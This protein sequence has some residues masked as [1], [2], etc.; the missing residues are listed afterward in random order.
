MGAYLIVSMTF[1]DLGWTKAYLDSV[2]E[3]VKRHGGEYL[4]RSRSV[5][6]IEGDGG[7]PDHVV[8]LTFPSLAAIERFM[9]SPDYAPFRDARIAATNSHILALEA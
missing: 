3:M 8:I 1:H 9:A 2:P 5:R 4:A 7:T 6:L